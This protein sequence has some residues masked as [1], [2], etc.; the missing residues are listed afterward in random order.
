M[1]KVITITDANF[2]EKTE[3]IKETEYPILNEYLE[4]GYTIHQVIEN[5][6]NATSSFFSITFVLRK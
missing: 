5:H 3:K 6:S 4:K 2:L 1:Q